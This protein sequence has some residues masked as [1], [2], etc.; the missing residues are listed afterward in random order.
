M[1]ER[2]R[3]LRA[4]MQPR[5]ACVRMEVGVKVEEMDLKSRTEVRVGPEELAQEE[6][7]RR[8]V[9]DVMSMSGEDMAKS[10]NGT[11][12]LDL[13][14]LSDMKNKRVVVKVAD[15]NISTEVKCEELGL[16]VEQV[17]SRH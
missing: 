16:R 13:Q 6:V 11:I 7:A 4:T 12:V 1:V 3:G 10:A 2:R 14:D 17:R 5:N 15:V 9:E 8:K